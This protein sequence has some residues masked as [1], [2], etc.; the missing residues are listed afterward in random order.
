MCG[1]NL[2]T[3]TVSSMGVQRRYNYALQPMSKAA[4]MT[5]VT[6]DQPEAPQYFAYDAMLNRRERPRCHRRSPVRSRRSPS[7]AYCAR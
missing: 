1:K 4:F 6:A 2:S 7:M 3:D 5:L